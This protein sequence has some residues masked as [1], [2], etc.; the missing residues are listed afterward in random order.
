MKNTLIIFNALIFSSAALAFG[1]P[2]IP[3]VSKSSGGSAASGPSASDSQEKI[4]TQFNTVLNHIL[5]AQYHVAE[6]LDLDE[7]VKEIK[8]QQAR[9]SGDSCKGDCPKQV[10][11]SSDAVQKS[12]NEKMAKSS[13]LDEDGKK[14][15]RKS[16]VPLAKGTYAMTKLGEA[17][18]D[19]SKSAKDEIKSAGAMGAIKLKKKLSSGLY[20]VKT[21]PKIIKNWAST[22]KSLIAFGKEQGITDAQAI[23]SKKYSDEDE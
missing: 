14:E 20:I 2:E 19:W 10:K 12:I 5:Q 15:L 22:S 9:L 23:G 4:V 17:A 18:K 8:T 6:A 1:L 16:Y 21:T 3:G 13:E 7:D 11:E